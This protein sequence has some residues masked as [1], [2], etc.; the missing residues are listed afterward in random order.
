MHTWPLL[1]V[2]LLAGCRISVGHVR[3]TSQQGVHVV[4]AMWAQ[5]LHQHLIVV[6]P[7]WMMQL[8][9]ACGSP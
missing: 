7:D 1:H 5:P 9:F 8:V 2:L 4:H 3:P 6:L